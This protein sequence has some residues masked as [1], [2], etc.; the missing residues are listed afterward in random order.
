MHSA[1][2]LDAEPVGSIPVID[3][4]DF[5]WMCADKHGQK[6]MDRR[7]QTQIVES[8]DLDALTSPVRSAPQEPPSESTQLPSKGRRTLVILGYGALSLIGFV[9]ASVMTVSESCLVA[10][11]C[12]SLDEVVFAVL[13][14]VWSA[15]LVGIATVGWSGRLWGARRRKPSIPNVAA[16]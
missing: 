9:L 1:A 7:L 2:G 4:I 13:A 6:F 15:L 10:D 11:R 14:I 5:A 8:S 3:L 12:S 16:R